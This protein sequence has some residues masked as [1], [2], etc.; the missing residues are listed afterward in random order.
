[1]V[2]LGFLVPRLCLGTHCSR[3]SASLATRDNLLVESG[4]QSLPAVR[5]QAEPGNELVNKHELVRHHQHL[6]VSLPV[7]S[8]PLPS[9][10]NCAPHC[11]LVSVGSRPNNSAYSRLIRSTG[12]RG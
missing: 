12:L 5:S 4:R 8:A 9:A 1:M 11:S 7:V 3:G 2:D 6:R 10:T